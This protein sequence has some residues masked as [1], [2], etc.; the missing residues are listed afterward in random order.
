MGLRSEKQTFLGCFPSMWLTGARDELMVPV[1]PCV[2]L[3]WCQGGE[4]GV[5]TGSQYRCS[6]GALH[7]LPGPGT[8][9]A[10]MACTGPTSRTWGK[11][12]FPKL[13]QGAACMRGS[14]LPSL[15]FIRLQKRP[16]APAC[17]P[18]PSP[19]LCPLSLPGSQQL[20]REGAWPER[21]LH[22]PA[23]TGSRSRS[24]ALDVRATDLPDRG[25]G[26]TTVSQW[27]GPGGTGQRNRSRTAA[28]V[29]PP[30]AE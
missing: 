2:V 29:T 11:D 12:V 14:L 26:Q 30:A 28:A 4:A 21:G 25:A 8:R 22:E 20:P 17:H 6:D 24:P 27:S 7:K 13:P 5:P 18:P 10:E 3:A 15:V 19:W 1:C 23:V 9:G 16:H